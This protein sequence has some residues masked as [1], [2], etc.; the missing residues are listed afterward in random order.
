M[1]D[2][3]YLT[4]SMKTLR[5]DCSG[6]VRFDVQ[7]QGGRCLILGDVE[8]RGAL[9]S[10]SLLSSHQVRILVDVIKRTQ[11]GFMGAAC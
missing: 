1:N 5:K 2:Q 7:G 3:T 8:G 6:R 9:M 11:T 10:F 4:L